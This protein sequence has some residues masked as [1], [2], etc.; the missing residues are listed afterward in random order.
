MKKIKEFLLFLGLLFAPVV[1]YVIVSFLATN[2]IS[3]KVSFVGLYNYIRMFTNDEMFLTS[4]LYSI[5]PP[6]ILSIIFVSVFRLIAY[7]VKNKIK[8][9]RWA[10]YLCSV[11]IG[12]LVSIFYSICLNLISLFKS[13]DITQAIQTLESHIGPFSSSVFNA[14]NIIFAIYIGVLTAFVFWILE[15]IIESVNKYIKEAK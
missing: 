1:F 2:L 13:S 11:F 10:F 6:F 12:G 9:Y 5:L 7:L 3:D 14:T 15:Q 4:L 8:I